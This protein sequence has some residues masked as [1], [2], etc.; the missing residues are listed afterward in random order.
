MARARRRPQVVLASL[1]LT[2]ALAV[3]LGFIVYLSVTSLPYLA[4]SPSTDPAFGPLNACVLG[5]LPERT[6]WASSRD[7]RTVAAW[8][9]DALVVCGPSQPTPERTWRAAGIIAGAFDAHGALW[10]AAQ[11]SDAAGAT[12]WVLEGR[13]APR[14]MTSA[15]AVQTL[16]G[17]SHGVVVLEATGRLTAL[18]ATGAVAGATE[19]PA[20]DLRAANLLSSGDGE[21]VA[22]VVGGGVFVLDAS[23]RLLRAEAPCNVQS[24]WWL[25]QGHT[26]LLQC[27]GALALRYDVD[28]ALAEAAPA[29]ARVPSTLVGPAP[30]WAQPCDVLPCSAEPP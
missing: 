27:A 25:A 13:A 26:A 7:A 15:L 9:S 12:L 8:S 22:V 23:A 6:G 17:T 20:G 10:V 30:L 18:D 5:A 28:T 3:A 1:L 29:R 19:L 4:V 14:P 11:A 16:A 21:R 2:V 24:M